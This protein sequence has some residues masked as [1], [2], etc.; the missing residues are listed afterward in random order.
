MQRAV[1][2]LTIAFLLYGCASEHI[3]VLEGWPPF[4]VSNCRKIYSM[5]SLPGQVS[6]K[7]EHLRGSGYLINKVKELFPE[8]IFKGI[9]EFTYAVKCD[10]MYAVRYFWW[11]R[12]DREFAGVQIWVVLNNKTKIYMEKLPYE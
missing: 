5:D 10:S 6:R 3:E 2:P 12:D 8:A 4:S 1:L 11:M 9:P 7:V